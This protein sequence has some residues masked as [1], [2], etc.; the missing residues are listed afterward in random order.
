MKKNASLSRRTFFKTATLASGAVLGA[1]L[2][3]ACSEPDAQ[4]DS[5]DRALG[6]ADPEFHQ[7]GVAG[8]LFSQIGYEIGYPVRIIARL[9]KKDLF[10]EKAICKLN[11]VSDEKKYQTGFNYWG[12]KWGSHWWIADFQAI[13]ETGEWDIEVSAD[14][15]RIFRDKGLKVGKDILWDSTI[16]LSSVDMLERRTHFTKVGAGWQDAGTLW[17]ESPAQSAMII[18]LAELLE[19]TSGRFDKAF[20]Q[21]IHKQIMVGCDYLVMT[22]E[23]AYELGFPEG[24]MSHDLLGHEKDVLPND[25][26]KAVVAL[27]KAVRLLPDEYQEKKTTYKITS[28]KTSKW[29]NTKAKPMGD[30]GFS[31]FLRGLSETDPVPN[32]E[33]QTRDLVMLCWASIEHWKNSNEKAK[34]MAIDLA[35]KI[36]A[37]QIPKEQSEDGYFGHF[38]EFNSVSYSEKSFIQ[39]IVHGQF[40]ADI[41]GFYPNYLMPIIEMLKLWP[42]EA[43]APKW[44]NCLQQFSYGYLIPSCENNPFLLV[45]QGIFGK[46]GPVWFCGTFHGTNAIYGYTAALAL[47]LSRLFNEPKLKNIAYG[48]LQWLVGLNGGITRENLREGCV[49]FST[50]V[51]ENIALPASMMCGVGSRWAGTWFQTRGIICNGFSTGKQFI[52]DTEPKRANDGPFSLT[53]E[54]WVPH[55]AGWLTGLMR[56]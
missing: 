35:N 55:S 53:D 10:H 19:H 56:L 42:D 17:V 51:P 29:L 14:N 8:I 1:P 12:E 40:G 11:P 23:K 50:D 28:Q 37:R 46:E 32:D 25:A 34:E 47:E 30:Y 45:P 2:V 27:E 6:F 54:D 4:R 41:G 22:Q 33:W 9:P 18:A 48:N 44:K 21:R 26:T 7:A 13:E 36:M 15:E 52:Y 43:D 16:E 38:K 3:T 24:A 49:I 39:G 31:R 5:D 20:L